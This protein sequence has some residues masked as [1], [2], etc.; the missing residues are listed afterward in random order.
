M[1]PTLAWSIWMAFAC[2]G[3]EVPGDADGGGVDGGGAD[4]GAGDGGAP[5]EIPAILASAAMTWTLDFDAAAEAQGQ[6]D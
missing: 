4:G 5:G 2:G 6:V 3:A 1:C